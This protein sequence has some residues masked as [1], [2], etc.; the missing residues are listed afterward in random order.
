MRECL[1][2]NSQELLRAAVPQG[3]LSLRQEI[4]RYLHD[5][6]G[7]DAQPSQIVLGAG[8]EYLLGL[9]TQLLGLSLIHI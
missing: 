5:F 7:I 2:E 6:R 3:N 4:V 8:S 9:I 1:N